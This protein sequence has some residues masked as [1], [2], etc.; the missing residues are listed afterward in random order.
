MS[1]SIHPPAVAFMDIPVFIVIQSPSMPFVV[2]TLTDNSAFI[3]RHSGYAF[4]VCN[5][6]LF[7]A[8]VVAR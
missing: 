6:T 1:I 3:N 8:N 2:F 7:V 5:R 4:L